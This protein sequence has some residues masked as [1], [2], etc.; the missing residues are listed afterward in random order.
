M[1]FYMT[2]AE[3]ALVVVAKGALLALWGW[4]REKKGS[5]GA[6]EGS[7]EHP[8]CPSSAQGRIAETPQ[9]VRSIK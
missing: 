6:S 4:W 3:V 7:A 8:L 2:T 9:E 1:P 5:D